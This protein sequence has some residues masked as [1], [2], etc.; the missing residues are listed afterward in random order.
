[1]GRIRSFTVTP[2]Q[3]RRPAEGVPGDVAGLRFSRLVERSPVLRAQVP[4]AYA[5]RLEDGVQADGLE[6]ARN[7]ARCAPLVFS[8]GGCSGAAPPGPAATP[9]TAVATTRTTRCPSRP[10]S[11]S[12]THSWPRAGGRR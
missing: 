6:D 2:E 8:P 12:A 11:G 7:I 1:M 4:A 3:R 5:A 10:W 9:T